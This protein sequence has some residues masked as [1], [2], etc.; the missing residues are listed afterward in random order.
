VV[1]KL[2]CGVAFALGMT[3]LTVSGQQKPLINQSDKEPECKCAVFPWTPETC[4]KQCTSRMLDTWSA[5]TLAT[6]LKLPSHVKSSVDA[7]K[8]SPK[9]NDKI[10]KFL[11]TD[12]GKSFLSAVAKAPK[13]DLR[14]LAADKSSS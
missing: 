8:S 9:T 4:V 6:T 5:D 2:T 11:L 13:S 12:D 14:K 7:V 3:C 10:E 1:T